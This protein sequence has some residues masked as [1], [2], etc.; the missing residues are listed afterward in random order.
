[1][2]KEDILKKV[3][4]ERKENNDSD[5]ITYIDRK[6]RVLSSSV[7]YVILSF[8]FIAPYIMGIESKTM[9]NFFG[10]ELP[11]TMFC[12]FIVVLMAAIQNIYLFFYLRKPI[13][14]LKGAVCCTAIMMLII[15]VLLRG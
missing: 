4:A 15:T 10:Y 3:Q 5:Y 6:A 1:M 11:F 13:H 12:V 7:I 9:L 2:N 14:A 8:I